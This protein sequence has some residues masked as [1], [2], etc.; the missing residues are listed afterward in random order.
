MKGEIIRTL[1]IVFTIFII[2]FPSVSLVFASSSS[3][4]LDPLSIPKYENQLTGPPPVYEP[5]KITDNNGKV[6]RYEYT[7]TMSSFKQQVLPQ[8]MGLL[9]DVWGYGGIAKDA[10]TGALLGF[11]Q[12]SPG[13][14]FE[15]IRDIPV[16]V[17]WVNNITSPYMFPVDPTIHWA[18]PNNYVMP[19]PPFPSYPPGYTEVQSAVPL[20]THL[21]GSETLSSYDGTPEE[22]FTANGVHGSQYSTYEKTDPN[23]AVYYYPNGQ[24]AATMWYHDHALGLTRINVMSGLA[25]FYLLRDGNS[26][27]DYV[28]PVLPTGNYEMPL[29]IQDR[30]FN[31]D[32]SLWFPTVGTNP[33]THPYWA[34]SFLGNTI[35]VNGKVWPNMN[36]NQGQYRF[37]LLDASNSRFYFLSFINTLTNSTVPFT[38][39]G[40]DGG[41]LKSQVALT[42]LALAPAERAEILVDFSGLPPGS[43]ILLKNSALTGGVSDEQTVGQ[44]MQFTVTAEDGYKSN[45]LPEQLNP[46]LTGSTFPTLPDPVK[47]RILTL[48][49]E[50]GPNGA[51]TMLLNGQSWE[52][53]V[54]EVPV[55]GTTEDWSFVDLTDGVHPIHLHLIQ[56]QIVSRQAI[57]ANAYATDWINLQRKALGNQTATPPWPNNF[58][59]KELPIEPYLIGSPTP[60][61][62][63][64]Q[65]WK[66][67]FLSYPFEVTVIRIRFATQNGSPFQF[68]ATQGPGYVWHCHILDHE[69]NEMMR[70]YKLVAA[71]A[72]LSLSPL[73]LGVSVVSFVIIIVVLV[74]TLVLRRRKRIEQT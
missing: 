4:P 68:D 23:A 35:M 73:I 9:T 32:G 56:F 8:S 40:S 49:R 16:Q 63:N 17:K 48:F 74:L 31:D 70:P 6:I 46:T 41:Y 53:E 2:V 61:P 67:T 55:I 43:K 15:A 51:L 45:M 28:A 60:A 39:I 57:N 20:V 21:H 10:L 7:V 13:P 11:V 50:N 22:W 19:M 54:S 37:R 30:T 47:N 38:Q 64:E 26:S 25:G 62:L 33:E 52:G 3:N 66:D 58:I 36:V 24:P 14:S 34:D 18:N 27:S 5:T 29:M 1:C 71:S 42:N 72:S 44:I 65:G 59:P 12:S 69:D